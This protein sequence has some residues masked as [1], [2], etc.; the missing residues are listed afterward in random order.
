MTKSSDIMSNMQ[1]LI[2]N[3]KELSKKRESVIKNTV[4]KLKSK[5]NLAIIQIGNNKESNKYIEHKKSFGGRVGINV[6]HLNFKKDISEKELIEKISNLN[7]NNDVHGIIVQLPL[8]K[9]LT[10]WKI[11][12]A[13]SPEKDV[14]GMTSFNLRLLYENNSFLFPAT[15]KGIITLLENY[16]IKITGKNVVIVGRSS[17]VGKPTALAF[18]NKNATV[19][20]CHSKTEN[21]K[22]ITRVADILITAIGSPKMIDATYIKKGCVVIDVGITVK[23]GIVLG[24]TNYLSLIKKVRAIT[25]VP[26]GVGPMTIVSLFE[27]LIIAY[28]KSNNK[29]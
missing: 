21:I 28:K 8:P 3:G 9:N 25:P 11:L 10:V 5:P 18:L 29:I 26:G 22:D 19:T 4:K 2:L 14:D 13:I 1:P 17:L 27:N 16:K 6:T 7:K 12:D 24:D 20:I 23:N 15:T